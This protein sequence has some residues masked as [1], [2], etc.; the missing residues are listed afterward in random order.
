[1][2]ISMIVAYG[3]NWE[4]GLN[5]KMLWHISEDF[6]NFKT[7]TSG[8]HILM[9]RKTFE[10]IGKPLPNRTS[11]VLS[12]SG[13]EHEGVHTFSDVQEAFNF[14]RQSAEE[15]LF[16]IGGANIYETLF[17]Y[18]DKMYLS[19]VDFE[20]VA[21][22]FLKPID[23]STWDLIEEKAYDEILEHGKVKSPA[24]KFKVWVKKD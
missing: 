10:S 19:E 13:F 11:L 21:D 12:N 9:G 20:G 4:I 15:E 18:V 1:M 14:A 7:I 16:I 6:K 23:F 5:N 22:A 3:K 17:P 2:K 24:W 8:H